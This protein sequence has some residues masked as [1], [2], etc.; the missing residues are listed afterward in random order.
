VSVDREGAEAGE[1]LVVA[2]HVIPVVVG[3]EDGG[4]LEAF[5]FEGGDNGGGLGRVDNDGLV[6]SFGDEEVGIVIA[7]AGDRQDAHALSIA[8]TA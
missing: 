6:R 1:E 3:V 2:A 8:A 5:A 4:E 7:Q